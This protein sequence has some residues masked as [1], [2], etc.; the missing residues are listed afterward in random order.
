MSKERAD[1]PA[2]DEGSGN[3]FADIDLKMSEDDMLK[4]HIALVIQQTI[5]KRGLTQ[6]EA[7][8]LMGVDQSKVSKIMRG[9]LSE[10][11]EGRLIAC[12]LNL[13][14][15]MEIRFPTR[16]GKDRGELRVR[17]A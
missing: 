15:D 12:L 13:G 9:R 11:K 3:V 7:G 16:W 2:V 4:V 6:A 17:C 14:R 10:F 8:K 1:V 5:K